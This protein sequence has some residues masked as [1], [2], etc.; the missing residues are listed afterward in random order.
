[1]REL[2][3]SQKTFLQRLKTETGEAHQ[4]LEQTKLSEN[5]MS[6]ALSKEGYAAYLQKML[7]LH[8]VLEENIFPRLAA[9][10]PDINERKKTASLHNDL[11][12][13][14]KPVVSNTFNQDLS[15]TEDIAGALGFMYVLEGSSLG[16]RIILK[17]LNKVFPGDEAVSITKYF[18]G[19]G[20]K[21]GSM[22]MKFLSDF[23]GHV[24]ISKMEDKVI[25]GAQQSFKVIHN[26]F[27]V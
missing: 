21:T 27:Q 4:Q 26:W 8:E 24:V 16:G 20:E 7:P 23:S 9:V 19:Y 13:L 2:N 3:E 22:W 1:M 5:I 14:P 18:A 15:F 11:G 17:N 12:N 10:F 6:E 25:D